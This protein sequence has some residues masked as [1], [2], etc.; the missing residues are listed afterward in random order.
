VFAWSQARAVIPG[1]YGVG[2]GLQALADQG[3]GGAGERALREMARD[4][5]FFRTFLDDIAMVLAKDDLRIARI[6]S[7]LSGPL[8]EEFF[9]L[10]RREHALTER[11]VLA[12]TQSKWLLQHDQRLALSIRL[13]NPYIDPISLLQAD[14]LKRWRDTG[15]ED[16]GLLRVL[17]ASINGVS[18]G[19]QNT[20]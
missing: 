20:G 10:I 13:R 11:W 8:H 7:R 16:N 15:R 18:Q 3:E 6:F 5:P 9:P 17:V 1:W 4:W 2:S 19:V 14:L 12:L